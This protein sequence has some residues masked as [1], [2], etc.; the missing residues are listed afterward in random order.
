MSNSHLPDL[1]VDLELCRYYGWSWDELERTP[2]FV[3]NRAWEWRNAQIRAG[4]AGP[5]DE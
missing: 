2:M 1:A 4:T 3:R 5:P